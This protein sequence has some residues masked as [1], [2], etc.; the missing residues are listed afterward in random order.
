MFSKDYD[1]NENSEDLDFVENIVCDY[2]V[3]SGS[4]G[5]H[6]CNTS[7]YQ[8]AQ[9]LVGPQCLKA[10]VS[11]LRKGKSDEKLILKGYWI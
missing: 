2:Y 9:H 7:N 4:S 10:W 11:N 6:P 3:V 8:M 1:I 5:L